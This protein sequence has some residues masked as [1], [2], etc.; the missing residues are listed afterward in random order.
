MEN[1]I[2]SARD[3]MTYFGYEKSS[4][5]ARDWKELTLEEKNWFKAEVG[6]EMS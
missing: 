3:I 2:A 4:E 1:G 6:K 5:F